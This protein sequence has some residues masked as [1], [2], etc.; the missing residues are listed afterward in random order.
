MTLDPVIADPSRAVPRVSRGRVAKGSAPSKRVLIVNVFF[1]DFRRTTGSPARVP[2]AMGPA[3]L[4]GALSRARCDVRLYN[5][6]YSGALEDVKLLAWPDMLVLTGLTSGFDRMLHLTAYAR[7]L[8][9]KV[10]VV[11]GGPAVRALPRYAARFFDYACLGD[12]EQLRSVVRDAFG[13]GYVADEMSPR[14]ELLCSLGRIGYVESSRYCNFRC[15]FCS[16]T[17]EGR[18]YRKYDLDYIREQILAVGKRRIVL[19]IDN[20]F[21]GNDRRFFL[22]R[23]ELLKEMRREGRLGEWAA[24]VTGD[25]FLKDENLALARQAGCRALFSG[26]ES[27]DAETLRSYNKK[28]N[29]HMP[30]VE[31]IRKCL[32]A[33]ILFLYG[34]MVDPTRRRL[35][36]LR[37]EIEFIIDTPEITLPGFLTLAI[38]LLGTPYFHECLEKDLFLPDIKLRDMDGAT[39]VQRPLDP[40]DEVVAFVRDMSPLRGYR[41][42]LARRS[43]GFLRRYRRTLGCIPMSAALI[44]AALLCAPEFV[45]SPRRIPLRRFPRTYISTTEILD[46]QYRPIIRVAAPYE[47][48]FKPTMVTDADGCL[49]GDLAE[50]LLGAPTLARTGTNGA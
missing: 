22:A 37:R 4:A 18:D 47:G 33:G 29:T 15:S 27:F 19:F 23:L 1:D 5:E 6:Q 3:Y 13:D 44:N 31:M 21:Y 10:I 26:V 39:L 50:D 48:H 49:A 45:T 41:G 17:G 20:N 12:I 30:Q 40:I 2:Q 43:V 16:L 42:R 11:A 9:P 38:P 25:F 24:L 46:P 8:N 36:D 35:A 28:Q 7:T 14:F 34:L 32:D